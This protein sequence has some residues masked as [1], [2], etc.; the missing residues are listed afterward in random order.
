M[1]VVQV[2]L[3]R[4]AVARPKRAVFLVLVDR[5]PGP[6]SVLSETVLTGRPTAARQPDCQRRGGDH[7]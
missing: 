4:T 6:R 3:D 5:R 2:A 1:V 7:Y